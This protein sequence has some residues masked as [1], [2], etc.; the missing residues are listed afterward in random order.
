[1]HAW[2]CCA[3]RPSLRVDLTCSKGGSIARGLSVRGVGRPAIWQ[4]QDATGHADFSPPHVGKRF[5]AK[6]PVM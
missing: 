2:S 5:R 1:M 4:R 3:V 6:V